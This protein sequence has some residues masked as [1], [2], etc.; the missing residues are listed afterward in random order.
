MRAPAWTPPPIRRCRY[1]LDRE[2]WQYRDRFGAVVGPLSTLLTPIGSVL[3]RLRYVGLTC[4]GTPL[5]ALLPQATRNFERVDIPLLPPLLLF[6]RGVDMVA[7][8][9]A[10]WNGEFIADL[11]A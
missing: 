10:K 4:G 7:V 6:A 5:A 3:R 1:R 2:R 8:D 11:Q 9:S